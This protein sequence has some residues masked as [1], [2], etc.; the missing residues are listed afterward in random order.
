VTWGWPDD[1]IDGIDGRIERRRG[2]CRRHTISQGAPMCGKRIANPT[3]Q[4]LK[5]GARVRGARPGLKQACG[6]ESAQ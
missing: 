1:G 5:E 3:D 4:K 2:V 6:F